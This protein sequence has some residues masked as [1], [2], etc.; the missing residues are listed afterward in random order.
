[1]DCAEID[2]VVVDVTF[3]GLLGPYNTY[4]GTGDFGSCGEDDI[5]LKVDEDLCFM[6]IESEKLCFPPVTVAGPLPCPFTSATSNTGTWQNE[7]GCD[8]CTTSDEF[9]VDITPA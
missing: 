1:M 7:A 9:T 8:C 5:T 6:I 2:G 3:A 4:T